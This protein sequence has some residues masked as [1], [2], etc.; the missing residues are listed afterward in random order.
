M[1]SFLLIKANKKL[2]S[3]FFFFFWLSNKKLK[4]PIQWVKWH[5]GLYFKNT[6]VAW[7][8]FEMKW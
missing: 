7:N 2:K 5:F 8:N 3:L 6:R 1:A 4:S